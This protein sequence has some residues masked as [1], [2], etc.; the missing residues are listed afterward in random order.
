VPDTN[1][2]QS[3][4]TKLQNSGVEFL[5]GL[6]NYEIELI[7]ASGEFLFPS[8]LRLFLQAGHPFSH[9]FTLWR[10]YL[11]EGQIRSL[12]EEAPASI[13]ESV[14]SGRFWFPKWGPRPSEKDEA[15]SLATRSLAEA[16]KL[17]PIY[18]HICLPDFP[19]ASA[20]PLFSV[21]AEDVIHG[22]PDLWSYLEHLAQ[23]I[24]D[25]DHWSHANFPSYSPEY[26]HIPFWTDLVRWNTI[27]RVHE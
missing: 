9:S 19:L 26:R 22:P 24:R 16:P 5:P 13:I 12:I 3:V 14:R 4:L 15:C 7:E 11:R 8:D 25:P 20:N 6:T 18:S 17:I 1:L 23:A 10:H 27:D 21:R 2:V